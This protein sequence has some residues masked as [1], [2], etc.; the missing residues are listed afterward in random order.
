MLWNTITAY[1]QPRF[2]YYGVGGNLILISAGLA[3]AFGIIWLL[4]HRPPIIREPLLWVTAIASAL[5]TVI[6]TAFIFIPL[7]YYYAQWLGNTFDAGTLADMVLVWS[8]PIVLVIGLVQEGAKMIPML[9][10]RTGDEKPDIRFSMMIGAVAGA[11]YGIFEAFYSYNQVFKTGWGWSNVT[12][13]GITALLPFWIY[14]WM[15]ACHI[16][17]SVLVGY[18]LGKGK[19]GGFYVL[20]AFLHAL[21]SYAAILATIGNITGNQLGIIIAAAGIIIIGISLWLRWRKY[22][23][24]EPDTVTET[25]PSKLRRNETP[26]TAM[27]KQERLVP[28]KQETLPPLVIQE[29]PPPPR[30]GNP[31]P[32]PPSKGV[33]PP[34]PKTL[35]S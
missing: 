27:P 24:A 30:Q 22:E 17:I 14:F 23:E 4:G 26:L 31:P 35:W 32:V 1:L 20:A 19:G 5:L 18:G 29:I 15:I 3:L 2:D 16:G 21:V 8:I 7:N 6:A 12:T 9:F 25:A 33:P 34:P 13:G 11:G 28:L 10:W